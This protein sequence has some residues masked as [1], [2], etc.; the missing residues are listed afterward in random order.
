MT[1][2]CTQK[3]VKTEDSWREVISSLDCPARTSKM[4]AFRHLALL[5]L[6]FGASGKEHFAI[7]ILLIM[8]AVSEIEPAGLSY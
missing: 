5:I 8:L 2:L 3:R 6:L 7:F 4:K 1:G